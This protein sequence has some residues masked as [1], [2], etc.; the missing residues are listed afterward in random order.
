M[1][2]DDLGSGLSALGP[3]NPAESPATAA[4]LGGGLG[5]AAAT[6]CPEAQAARSAA[7]LAA[8]VAADRTADDAA[9]RD[10][11]VRAAG[12]AAADGEADRAAGS[13]DGRPTG[14]GW[15]WTFDWEVRSPRGFSPRLPVS[16]G[17]PT[18]TLWQR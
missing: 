14:G 1:P 2:W 3:E 15:T 6:G 11:Q 17:F 10:S 4:A 7:G 18:S 16:E 8:G 12:G 9:S 5:M 13:G